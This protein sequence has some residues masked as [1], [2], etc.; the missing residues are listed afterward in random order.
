M[1]ER[2]GGSVAERQVLG[3]A[4]RVRVVHDSGL[5]ES[6]AAFGVFALGQMAQT[7]A[8]AQD[9]AGAGDF[10]PFGHGLLRFDAFGTSHKFIISITKGRA[11]YAA[12]ESDASAIFWRN[13]CSRLSGQKAVPV[14][15][16]GLRSPAGWVV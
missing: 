16:H 9:F 4:I 15:D 2:L 13:G 8:T 10:E 6:A 1:V 3:D 14:Q 5:A 11:L 7:R 12:E